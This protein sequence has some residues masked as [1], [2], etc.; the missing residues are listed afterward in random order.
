MFVF[1][2]QVKDEHVFEDGE[3]NISD[4]NRF[5]AYL[6]LESCDDLGPGRASSDSQTQKAC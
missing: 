6:M 2:Q 1:G 3:L 4:F 5:V